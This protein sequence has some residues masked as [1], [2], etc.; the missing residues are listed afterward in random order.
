[1]KEYGVESIKI[2]DG[3]NAVRK[4]PS[5]YIGN[6]GIEGLH[7]L[8][9][10]LVDNSLDEALE[11]YC[12]KIYVT[13]H[14]DNSVAVEDNGRGIPVDLHREENMS[15]L[16][17]VLTKLHAGGKFDKNTYKFSAGL[18]GV[19]LSVV[20]ALSEYIEVEVRREGSVYFQRY[21]RGERRTP[22]KV[23]GSTEKTGT[24]IRFRP[25]E[26]LFESIE[27]SFE[28]LAQRMRE[29]SFLN[30]GI[31]I[32]L[33]D[34]RKAR[35]QEFKHDGGITAFVHY[36]NQNKN[37]VFEP[38]IYLTG[39]RPG[40]DF[41]EA[42][43]QYND[44]YNDNI[45]S[46]VNNVSTHDGGSHVS[47]FRSAL[48]RC[49]N[50]FAQ[51]KRL[52]K[53]NES[54]SGDDVNEGLVAV[55][56]IKIQNP[57][58]EGQTKSK[59]GNSEI[60]GLSESV[61]NESLSEYFDLYKDAGKA[62]V[63]KGIEARQAREA[64]KKAKELIKNKSL[65]EAAILPGKLADCQEN[66]PD[67]R[68][69]YIVEGD[70]AGGSAKQ[71]R[72]RK[73]QAILPLKGKILNVE[74]ARHEK[75]LTNQEIRSIFLA[76][77]INGGA[78]NVRYKKIIIMTDAD[79][80]GSHI[81]TL[82][83]TLFYRR[84]PEVIEKGYL[85]IA[86]PPLYKVTA[87]RHEHY[88]KDEEEFQKFV[89]RRSLEKVKCYV[90]GHQISGDQLRQDIEN[91]RMVEQYLKDMRKIGFDKLLILSLFSEHIYEREDFEKPEKLLR[92]KDNLEQADYLVNFSLDQE[93]N[94]FTLAV[95]DKDKK[96]NEAVIDYEFCSQE[97]YRGY[98]RIY[99]KI[100]SYYEREV[101]II[102]KDT[103]V[104]CSAAKQLFD[105]VNEKGKE[106]LT[107]Q[108]YKGL[109]EMNP[110]QLWATTMDPARRRLVR[111]AIDDEIEVDQIF[112]ILMGNNIESRRSFIQDNAVDVRNLD[113]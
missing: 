60:K 21:E 10:E 90:D 13:I 104:R 84:I 44:G 30:N 89:M 64:A 70:S 25:D 78:E 69:L 97:N 82:L 74:K 113:I 17:I 27:F 54:L 15:A 111:V 40:L 12:D 29:I 66:N 57:Q 65:L 32:I 107:V 3:L 109:G 18:H 49:I 62:I 50:N 34:E 102:D 5:M 63:N 58:F 110:E 28:I 101:R 23:I 33:V 86:Q 81:Q 94:L 72:D 51:H 88:M 73:T 103:S 6:T 53:P 77:G 55:I 31:H 76:L 87:N 59:L 85:Y 42:A 95:T 112:T 11:G 26:E 99:G 93:H 52:L 4:V 20:N 71:G 83:L 48:T 41:F 47:G 36:L 16:E 98:F 1:M 67:L 39:S 9:Y 56:K 46:F 2:L 45:Y 22:L 19:G 38:P 35:R 61:M 37:V 96:R 100:S 43:I 79:V 14:R 108:R 24:K 106:G 7:H 92:L 75:I 8:V 91:L 68:E 105:F 80:D